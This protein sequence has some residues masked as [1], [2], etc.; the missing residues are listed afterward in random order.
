MCQ[1]WRFAGSQ[2]IRNFPFPVHHKTTKSHHLWIENVF[3]FTVDRHTICFTLWCRSEIVVFP[4]GECAALADYDV[5]VIS[6]DF[7]NNRRR[8][9]NTITHTV[10]DLT[11]TYTVP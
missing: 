1:L 8:L 3:L 10:C 6:V 5:T 4:V 9:I 7:T 11:A 2:R